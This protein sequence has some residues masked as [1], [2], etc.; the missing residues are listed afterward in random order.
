VTLLEFTREGLRGRFRKKAEHHLP[1]TGT[2]PER[3]TG[4][5]ELKERCQQDP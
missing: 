4:L 5:E 2:T 3:A 1:G